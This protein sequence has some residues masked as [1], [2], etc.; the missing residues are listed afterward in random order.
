MEG[1]I[2]AYTIIDLKDESTDKPLEIKKE[3]AP[4]KKG[5]NFQNNIYVLDDKSDSFNDID[6]RWDIINLFLN[7]K[8]KKKNMI[9]YASLPEQLLCAAY[10]PFNY[11]SYDM[12]MKYLTLNESINDKIYYN[13]FQNFPVKNTDESENDYNNRVDKFKASLDNVLQNSLKSL[14]DPNKVYNNLNLTYMIIVCCLLWGIIIMFLLKFLY[15]YYYNLYGLIIISITI[16]ILL[17]GIIW[18]MINIMRS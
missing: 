13:V 17:F 16:V 12:N 6:Y 8:T 3:V 5:F 1:E 4:D 7:D 18:K 14:D 9:Y 10:I 2:P 11:K 15:Y